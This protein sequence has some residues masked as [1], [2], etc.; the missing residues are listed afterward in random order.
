MP[1]KTLQ[2]TAKSGAL[3]AFESTELNRYV[4]RINGVFDEQ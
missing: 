4:Q 2:L 3:L 1:N